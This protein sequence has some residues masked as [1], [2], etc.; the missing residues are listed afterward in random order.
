MTQQLTFDL[1]ATVRQGPEEFFVSGANEQAFALIQAPAAWP[2]GKLALVGPAGSG[3]THLA[4]LFAAQT[5]AV[6]LD[7]DQIDPAQPLPETPLVVE[8]GERLPRACEEWLFHTHNRLR[9]LNLPFLLTGQ[10][11]PARWDISLPDLKSRLSAATTATISDPDDALLLA[12]LL[13]HF[14]DR[15]ISPSPDAITYLQNR[16]PRSFAAVQAAVETLDREALTQRKAL[17]RTFVREVLDF[18]K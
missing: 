10:E 9:A 4:R 8:N 13:K 7:A 16:L 12:V 11:A 2:D 18:T 17:T 15:Q 14:A 6:I 3:K 1:P 5:G